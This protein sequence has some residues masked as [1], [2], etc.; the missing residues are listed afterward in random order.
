[1]SV[2]N[3]GKLVLG[4][5]LLL[6]SM[7]LT[8]GC[9][10]DGA[11]KSGAPATTN[12][13]YDTVLPKTWFVQAL[14]GERRAELVHQFQAQARIRDFPGEVSAIDAVLDLM[15]VHLDGN[16]ELEYIAVIGSSLGEEWLCVFRECPHGARLIYAETLAGGMHRRGSVHVM[17]I[18]EAVK[19]FYIVQ[20]ED[21]G[22][23][24]LEEHYHI[25]RMLAGR[26]KKV[27]VVPHH[28][29][30]CGWNTIAQGIR[31]SVEFDGD[32]KMVSYTYTFSAVSLDR[33]AYDVNLIR[34]DVDIYYQWDEAR[35][36]YVLSRETADYFS[37]EQWACLQSLA[38][39][40]NAGFLHAFRKELAEVERTG[41]V[42]QRQAVVRLREAV[43][44]EQKQPAHGRGKA[45]R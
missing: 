3:H 36:R 9:G 32:L 16:P 43:S 31:A 40:S 37:P 11:P 35:Q 22:T 2:A 38:G 34:G 24:V 20:Q 15:A 28:I 12:G 39:F 8:E 30:A 4:V 19:P 45:I 17:N 27:L 7:C 29:Y 6:Y 23:G 10:G 33:G 26:I 13:Y 21:H 14:R 41:T 18:T 1:M 42:E 5:S 25:Y 44:K